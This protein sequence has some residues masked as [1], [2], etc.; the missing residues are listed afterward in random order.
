MLL[1]KVPAAHRLR[2]RPPELQARGGKGLPIFTRLD[3]SAIEPQSQGL[4]R[5]LKGFSQRPASGSEKPPKKGGAVL[6][7]AV[8]VGL[9]L[10]LAKLAAQH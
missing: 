6:G 10:M 1:L 8:N 9:T 5:Y 2:M 3:A 4:K 7:K